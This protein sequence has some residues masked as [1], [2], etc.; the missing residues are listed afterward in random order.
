MSG[1]MSNTVTMATVDTYTNH[2]HHHSEGIGV[3]TAV[4]GNAVAEGIG[5][6]A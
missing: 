2:I 3:C 5:T 4:C 6:Q 1:R